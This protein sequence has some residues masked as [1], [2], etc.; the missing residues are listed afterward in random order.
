MILIIIVFIAISLNSSNPAKS[1]FI[2]KSDEPT[3]LIDSIKNSD[4]YLDKKME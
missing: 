2:N 3:K 4:G 1:Q